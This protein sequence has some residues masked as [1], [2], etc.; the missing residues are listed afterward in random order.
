MI[1]VRPCGNFLERV[2]SAAG[3]CVN[4]KTKIKQEIMTKEES[5]NRTISY[6]EKTSNHLF[7][8]KANQFSSEKVYLKV[9]KDGDTFKVLDGDRI[10]EINI[11]RTLGYYGGNTENVIS[12]GL[13]V[14]RKANAVKQNKYIR[15]EIAE[16]IKKLSA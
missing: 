14:G 3:C 4:I 5:K 2:N 6:L 1:E 8:L 11:D 15:K 12:N 16:K 10:R 13:F 7:E 9:F